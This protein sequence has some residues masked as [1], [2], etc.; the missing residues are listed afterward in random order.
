MGEA[1]VAKY[2]R[3]KGF[4]VLTRNYRLPYGEIDIVASKAGVVHFIEVKSVTCE[5]SQLPV[6]R[7]MTPGF[8]PAERID[9]R[10]LLKIE[11]AGQ[12]YLVSGGL[13]DADWQI[14]AA[15]VWIDESVKQARVSFF[16]N[17]SSE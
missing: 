8:N 5:I 6:S 9:R 10:K 4:I 7:E 13:A 11:K 17:V 15:L 1:I 16:E 12:S 2:L 14:D 3:N